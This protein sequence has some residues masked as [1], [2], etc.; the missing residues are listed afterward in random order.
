[1]FLDDFFSL[2]RTTVIPRR[3]RV[4]T[5]RFDSAAGI[6][7]QGMASKLR[8]SPFFERQEVPGESNVS[9]FGAGKANPIVSTQNVGLGPKYS[10]EELQISMDALAAIVSAERGSKSKSQGS[11][12]LSEAISRVALPPSSM[13]P[14]LFE[15]G[16]LSQQEGAQAQLNNIMSLP[17]HS[18]ALNVQ[19]ALIARMAEEQE[20]LALYL[21]QRQKA[22]IGLQ[23]E[24][25]RRM[26]AASFLY[27]SGVVSPS[28]AALNHLD[29]VLS[30]QHSRISV[31]SDLAHAQQL[32]RAQLNAGAVNPVPGALSSSP[33]SVSDLLLRTNKRGS[34]TISEE[35]LN[36][37]RS[38]D[39]Q[40]LSK[41]TRKIMQYAAAKDHARSPADSGVDEEG[42]YESDEEKSGHRFRAY[43]FEQWTEKFQ[44]LCDFRKIRG[45]CQVPHTFKDNPSLARWVKRQR[46]QYKL[47]TEGQMSTMTDQRAKLLED[48]GF[49][50]DSHAAAWAD[51]L[52]ELK[53]YA[54]VK[55]NCNVPSTFPENP[56]LATWVKCQRRQYKLLRD[57]RTSNMTVDRVLQLEK[58]GFV[59]EVR[60]SGDRESSN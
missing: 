8:L 6:V 22:S 60:K 3:K 1:M 53:D 10:S 26:N 59:W 50:W 7:S 12:A 17:S 54:R 47:K 56:Q 23:L 37:C 14:S 49:I 2:C 57:K 19:S 36:N 21:Q 44:E 38:E 48:I 40:P 25:L 20:T 31:A 51:K 11:A 39:L 9:G 41:K 42:L 32:L 29:S 13:R 52:H 24:Q 30:A 46:Y 18:A 5:T 55:G 4:S 58:I 28:A 16:R 27:G 45:H 15:L 33:G 34:D 43:Q 35:G